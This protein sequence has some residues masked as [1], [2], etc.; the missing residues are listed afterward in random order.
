MRKV[1][2]VSLALFILLLSASESSFACSCAP[3]P[4]P[5]K[6]QVKD[7]FV[8]STAIFSG[9]VISVTPSSEQQVTVK[10]KVGKSW[11]GK[12]AEEITLTTASNSAMCGYGFEAG[13]TYLVYANGEADALMVSICSR[14]K[15]ATYKQDIKYLNKLK[16]Q[17]VK[18]T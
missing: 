13:K 9:E 8:E 17:K 12:P 15:L 1:A 3:N 16:R 11:K 10:L 5:L 14:T 6:G 4:K 18:T 2:F 7:A